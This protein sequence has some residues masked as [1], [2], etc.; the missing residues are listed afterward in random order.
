MLTGRKFLNTES[1]PDF[2]GRGITTAS[3]QL[4]GKIPESNEMLIIFVSTGIRGSI[5]DFSRG[6]GI[7]SRQQDVDLEFTISM[8]TLSLVSGAN[9][10]INKGVGES[11]L[12]SLLSGTAH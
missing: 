1:R 6:V 4:T 3:F 10:P 5:Q 9:V 12:V 2:F 8:H 11:L 7:G